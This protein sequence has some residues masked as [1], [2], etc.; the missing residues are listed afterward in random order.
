MG[1]FLLFRFSD[2]ASQIVIQ[3]IFD[4]QTVLEDLRAIVPDAVPVSIFNYSVFEDHAF[5]AVFGFARYLEITDDTRTIFMTEMNVYSMCI[6][7][8]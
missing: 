1:R 3:Y 8:F 7:L 6:F 4:L 5:V 2:T